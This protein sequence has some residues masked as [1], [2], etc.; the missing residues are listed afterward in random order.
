MEVSMKIEEI[1]LDRLLSHPANAN[2]MREDTLRKLRRH[3]EKQGFYEPLSVRHHPSKA[4][5]YELLNGHH[6]KRVL[7][8]L[9]YAQAQCVVWQVDDEQALLLLATLNRLCGQDD[10][11]KRA[12]LLE[13]LSQ[14]LGREE[15]LK[16]LPEKRV[17]LE[18]LLAVRQRAAVTE[19]KELPEIPQAMTFFVNGK[20]KETIETS[21]QK[22]REK[23]G[24]DDPEV[25]M[26][27]GDLLAVMA[28]GYLK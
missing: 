15:L 16:Q 3:I 11:Y 20:Q 25:K 26:T 2:V 14:R 7:E 28:G 17:Q 24:G 13:K 10:A 5:C 4:G 9:E 1:A 27:R 23:V 8:Q 22:V 6:R 19:P 18:K 21:L 12:E